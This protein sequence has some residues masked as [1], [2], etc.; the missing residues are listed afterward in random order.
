MNNQMLFKIT[1]IGIALSVM[2][3][4]CA[5]KSSSGTGE[6]TPPPVT[7]SAPIQGG[8][9][10]TA[11]IKAY[12]FNP[13]T[14]ADISEGYT[15][16]QRP[17][18]IMINNAAAAMPQRG[19]GSADVIYEMVTEGGVTRLMAMYS[20]YKAIPQTGPVRSAR[21]Q[22]L[23]MALAQNA[24]F[25]HIG[26]SI[27]AQNLINQYSYQDIDGMYLGTA[28]FAF[29]NARN[30]A[31]KGN[32]HCW[33]TDAEFV[34]IGMEKQLISPAGA[35][36]SLFKFNDKAAA[37]RIPAEGDAPHVK[38]TFS[39]AS[40]VELIYDAASGKYTKTAFGAP[41][42]DELTGAALAFDNAFILGCNISLKPD[43]QCTEFDL[44]QGTGFY[45]TQGKYES[46]TW[47]KGNPDQQLKIYGADNKELTINIGKSYIAFVGTNQMPSLMMNA[48]AP[49]PAEPPAAEGT[50]P[51]APEGTPQSAPP[52]A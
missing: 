40:E 39:G 43:G 51:A 45:I 6:I 48:A 22:H 29:D 35:Y 20:D 7:E 27:Y 24:V 52:A 19:I 38:W 10:P 34:R 44:T 30:L 41:H 9:N 47:T 5:P 32:E 12:D 28:C 1:A 16:G 21:D 25:V 33:F 26:S 4:S 11:P 14:G 31:G 49:P 37:P 17:V 2:L 3:V 42:I 23:Q 13:L 8:L 15:I 36:E 18:A 46:V 50:P